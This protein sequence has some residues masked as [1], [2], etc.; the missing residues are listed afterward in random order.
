VNAIAAPAR[1][2]LWLRIPI[3]LALTVTL[4]ATGAILF[5]TFWSDTKTQVVQEKT[6]DSEDTMAA[7]AAIE[8]RNPNAAAIDFDHV[9]DHW[10]GDIVAVCGRV[11]IVEDQDSFEG[12]ERFVYAD[13]ELTLEEADG[14]DAVGRKWND[15]CA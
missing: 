13:G 8:A 10:T 14:S 3:A 6:A 15:L 4:A 11:N 7:K 12:F 5:K 2:T 1:R 9:F